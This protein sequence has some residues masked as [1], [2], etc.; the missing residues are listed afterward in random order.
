MI[1]FLGKQ[2]NVSEEDFRQIL[3]IMMDE[4]N[5]KQFGC[6]GRVFDLAE[7]KRPSTSIQE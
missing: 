4:I 6:D 3:I 2:Y 7:L 1:T 5:T